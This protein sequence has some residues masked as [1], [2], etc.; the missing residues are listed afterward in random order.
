MEDKILKYDTIVADFCKEIYNISN[1]KK[2]I[3]LHNFNPNSTIDMLF[4]KM[5]YIFTRIVNVKIE[6]GMSK[7]KF[8]WF[9]RKN[10]LEIF[11]YK[12]SSS[13]IV[14]KNVAVITSIDREEILKQI[15]DNRK[16]SLSILGE[17]YEEYYK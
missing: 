7:W 4:L 9:Y 8:F 10:K 5:G 13:T 17:I 14:D 2:T 12:P 16:E 1:G 3:I 15:C 11:R 6:I